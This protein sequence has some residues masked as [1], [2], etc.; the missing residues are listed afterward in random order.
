MREILTVIGCAS[1]LLLGACTDGGATGGG[2]KGASGGPSG[3]T[4]GAGGTA[5]GGSGSSSSAGTGGSSAGSG[6]SASGA[7]GT[8]AGSGPG[9]VSGAGGSGT[10]QGECKPPPAIAACDWRG[11]SAGI[12]QELYDASQLDRFS[13]DCLQSGD[14]LYS[15]PCAGSRP[16]GWCERSGE[17]YESLYRHYS[18]GP[19]G[20]PAQLRSNCESEEGSVWCVGANDCVSALLGTCEECIAMASAPGG[21]CETEVSKCRADTKCNTVLTCVAGCGRDFECL[22]SCDWGIPND[23]ETSSYICLFSHGGIDNNGPC[24]YGCGL[25]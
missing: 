17:P 2:E 21:C 15:G 14:T 25:P 24:G 18:V 3:G 7:G 19:T 1:F 9:G 10:S 12:C 13:E 11:G 4:G 6:G 16:I 20:S 23:L 8:S 22:P 5:A